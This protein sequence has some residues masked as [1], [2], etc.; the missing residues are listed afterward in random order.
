MLNWFIYYKSIY[1]YIYRMFYQYV[2]LQLKNE[3]LKFMF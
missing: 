2:K 1:M 3:E